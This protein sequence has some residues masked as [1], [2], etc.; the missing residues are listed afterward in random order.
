MAN[1]DLNSITHGNDTYNLKDN[2]KIPLSGTSA[3]S[4]SIVPDTDN[5][6][7]F[8][9]SSHNLKQVYAKE[10]RHGLSSGALVCSG[11]DGTTNGAYLALYG[12]N[13]NDGFQ[14]RFDLTA[15]GS[16][17]CKLTGLPS[18]TLT[19]N[20]DTVDTIKEQGNGY[21]R[22]SNGLQIC[23][24]SISWQSACNTSWGSLYETRAMSASYAKSFVDV[25]SVS[26]SG[27]I[28]SSSAMINSSIAS[29]TTT[30]M[31]YLCRATASSTTST[32]TVCYMAIGRWK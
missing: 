29:N 3:L 24:G 31:F 18:G 26:A 21:I 25:P 20:G 22:Y 17:N 14:G 10:I 27:V 32:C 19:W 4:G 15:K 30:P 23:W 13:R 9:D 5:S 12:T 2:S 16:S 1:Y 8:G 11:G 6:Y 7:D 28:G